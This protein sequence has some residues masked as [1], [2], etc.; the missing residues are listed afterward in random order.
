MKGVISV[1]PKSKM[2][3]WTYTAS[4]T[5]SRNRIKRMRQ[6]GCRRFEQ[7]AAAESYAAF[8]KGE[9]V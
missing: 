5:A 9:L 7:R 4:R 6:K 1:K 3:S 8:R 2:D